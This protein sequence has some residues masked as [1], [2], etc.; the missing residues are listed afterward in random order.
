M[1]NLGGI[2]IDIVDDGEHLQCMIGVKMN[3]A[4][5]VAVA[6]SVA[7]LVVELTETYQRFPELLKKEME[8]I[9]QGEI[10][11]EDLK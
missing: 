6:A 8:K 1:K 2:S 4:P 10:E 11:V 7:T 5:Y 3:G 9:L